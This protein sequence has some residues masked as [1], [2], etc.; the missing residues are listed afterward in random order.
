ME[1]GPE[2]GG[3]DTAGKGHGSRRK[4]GT[5]FR[6][7]DNTDGHRGWKGQGAGH[8]KGVTDAER[9]GGKGAGNAGAWR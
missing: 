2:E 4:E 3:K 5:P 8:D 1:L 7:G 9:S 6:G